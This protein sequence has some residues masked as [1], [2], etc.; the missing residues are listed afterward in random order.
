MK[1]AALL[2]VAFFFACTTATT[3]P[4]QAAAPAQPVH[5]VIVGTTDVHG[6]FAGHQEGYGGLAT[7]ASYVDALRAANPD[8]VVLVD[9]GDMFQGT[10]ESNIFEG[11]PVVR[12]YNMLGYTAAAVGNHEFDYGPIGPDAVARDASQDPLGALKKNAANAKYSLLSANMTEKAS[13]RVPAWAKPS[14]MITVRGVKLGIIGLSTPDTPNVTNPQN[15]AMLNFGDPVAA[16][17]AQAAELRA[18]G[19]DAVIVIAHMGGRCA[20]NAHDVNDASTCETNHEVM[21]YLD[22]LPRGTIDAYFAGHTHSQMRKLIN[23]VAVVQALAYS[24]EFSTVDLWVDPSQHHVVAEKTALRPQTMICTQVWSGTD[25]CDPKG[26]KGGATLV[27]RV[28]EG[29]TITPDAKLAAL[30]EPYLTQTEAKRKERL[31]ITTSA[32]FT[33]IDTADSPLGDLL[34]DALRAYEKTD[35]AILNPGGLRTDLRAGELVYSDIFEVSPFDNYPAVVTLTGAQLHELLRLTTV[36]ERR[37]LQVSGIRYV[38]DRLK[39]ADKPDAERDRIVSITLPNGQPLDPNATY[40]VALPDFLAAG[41]D[42]LMPIMSALPPD[43]LKIKYEDGPLREVF[44]AAL[45]ARP[46][47]I[48]PQTDGRVSVLN[49]KKKSAA[50]G[51]Q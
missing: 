37:I 34:T 31:N 13:G 40:T 36:G 48:A 5:L 17:V 22:K 27:P 35:V 50:P 44:I 3:P 24:R 12:G 45:K 14:M 9:S 8:R 10:L 23:G 2:L 29:K 33:R 47:P 32:V 28:F 16:T 38:V 15:V 39:E 6:W 20:D 30:F 43:R 49:E 4:P 19:A 26:N 42:G 25:A 1:R 51:G 21:H 41:G 7:L 18:Q 46:Q 11:E